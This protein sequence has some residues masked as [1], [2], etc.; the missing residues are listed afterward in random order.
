MSLFCLNNM[1][2]R[3]MPYNIL[4]FLNNL[5]FSF[6]N[7]IIYYPFLIFCYLTFRILNKLKIQQ[8]NYNFNI[9][10]LIGYKLFL[11]L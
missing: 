2:K 5:I 11:T 8:Q 10:F 4:F 3:V 7:L 9:Y 6:K 1:K